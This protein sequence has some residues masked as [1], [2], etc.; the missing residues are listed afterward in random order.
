MCFI[1]F[2]TYQNSESEVLIYEILIFILFYFLLVMH[3]RSK[4][5]QHFKETTL[6]KLLIQNMQKLRLH[7]I[8]LIAEYIENRGMIYWLLNLKSIKVNSAIGITKTQTLEL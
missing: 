2:S 8:Q 6:L 7:I 4:S 3:F 1:G 5:F